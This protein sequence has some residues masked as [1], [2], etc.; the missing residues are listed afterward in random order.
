MRRNFAFAVLALWLCCVPAQAQTGY[1]GPRA[2][3]PNSP[4]HTVSGTV[5]NS[6]TGEPIPHALVQLMGPLQQSGLTDSQ[7]SFRFEDI[8][9]GRALFMARKPGFFNSTELSRGG[10]GPRSAMAI[11]ADVSSLVLKLTPE[12]ILTG[13][14]T[15]DDGDPLERVQVRLMRQVITNGR[16]RW[17]PRSQAMTDE[18]GEFRVANLV[19]GTYYLLAEAQRLPT[20]RAAAEPNLGY[21]PAYY[22][23]VPERAA[24]SAI[25]VRGGQTA[26]VEFRLRSQPL[27]DV[28]GVVTGMAPGQRGANIQATNRFGDTLNA[29]L[30]FDPED[31]SFTAKL[32]AG[33]YTVRAM[34]FG[35][36]GPAARMSAT[37]T[38]TANLGGIRLP[39]Q[40]A[41]S[42]PVV[43]R[44][45]F[46][47]NSATGVSSASMKDAGPAR[48]VSLQLIGLDEASAAA[49][50]NMYGAGNQSLT[51]QNVEPGRY[52][53]QISPHGPWY[54]ASASYGQAD[55]LRDEMVVTAGG[56]ARGIDIVLRDDGG[57]LSGSV[58]QDNV[59]VPAVVLV[60]PERR[61][62]VPQTQSASERGLTINTLAPGDY[63]L[64]AFDT[65]D[66]LEY[67]NRDALEPYTSQATHVTVNSKGTAQVALTLIQRGEP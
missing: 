2:Y 50:A 32:P 41:M 57:S 56:D 46:S 48:Y 51:L 67:T 54:V 30:H 14:V 11:T 45:E 3:D 65:V 16:K 62:T 24:A 21:A 44:T 60:V 17:E 18:L 23:G 4:K 55:L 38:V 36:Q 10:G 22:P 61:S 20:A 63:L 40:E 49:Y 15:G 42:I 1:V 39:L 37:L 9:E 12:G 52:A 7:G 34:S 28:S 59:A 53:A 31:N 35:P 26:Q 8:P 66:G 33:T 19:P 27:Y 25:E 43:V 13:V 64:Y 58:T 6:A 29:N 47:Q 5:V